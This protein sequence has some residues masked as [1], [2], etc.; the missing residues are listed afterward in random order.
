MAREKDGY[1]DQLES[2]IAAFPDKELLN[3]SEV[4]AYTGRSRKYCAKRFPFVDNNL[5]RFITRT[6][7]ARVLVK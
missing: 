7:L 6:Q 2:I 5:G 1:R 4:S 3:V